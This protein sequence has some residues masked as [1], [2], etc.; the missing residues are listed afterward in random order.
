MR[1][2]DALGTIINGDAALALR[3]AYQAGERAECGRCVCP[4]YRGPRALLRM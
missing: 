2:G 4:L 3:R 1:P